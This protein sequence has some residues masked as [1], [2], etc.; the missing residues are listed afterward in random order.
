MKNNRKYILPSL[1]FISIFINACSLFAGGGF[2][3]RDPVE[4]PDVKDVEM[5]AIVTKGGNLK[6]VAPKDGKIKEIRIGDERPI[7]IA[8]ILPGKVI[9]TIDQI[10]IF[11]GSPTCAGVR[12]RI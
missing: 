5:F 7:N 11:S 12:S 3:D 1:L 9:K 4:L 8:K 6:F 2:Y 10:L